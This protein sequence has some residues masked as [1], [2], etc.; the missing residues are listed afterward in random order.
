MVAWIQMDW[1]RI[2]HDYVRRVKSL[3]KMESSRELLRGVENE[4]EPLHVYH[5]VKNTA[6]FEI[7]KEI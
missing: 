4:L 7:V 3:R 5:I 1:R 6:V 2:H